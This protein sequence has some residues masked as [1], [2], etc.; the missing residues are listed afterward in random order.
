MHII[1]KTRKIFLI[2]SV[3]VT[4]GWF[5]SCTPS[6]KSF[7]PEHPLTLWYTQPAESWMEYSLPIGNGHMGA[8]LF[9]GIEKDEIQFNEKTLW[10]GKPYAIGSRGKYMNFGSVFAEFEKSDTS[11]TVSH[12]TRYLDLETGVGGVQYTNSDGSTIYDR[13][14]LASAPDSAVVALYKA[15]GK[16]KLNVRFSLVPAK[17]L[18]NVTVKYGGAFEYNSPVIGYAV[19][20]YVSDINVGGATTIKAKYGATEAKKAM[21]SNDSSKL[22]WSDP[23]GA[24]CTFAK[25]LV[26]LQNEGLLN[27]DVLTATSDNC[28]DAFV[29]GKC[30]MFSNGMWCLSSILEKDPSMADKI[31]FAP[32]PSF[33][34]DGV[35]VVLVAEDSGYSISADT[36]NVEEAKDF[37]TYL[38][39]AEN[40]KKYAESLGSPSAF[41]DVDAKWAP[42]AV[43]DGV[44]AAI[45]SATNIGFTNEKPAGFSGDDAGR[46]VQELLAG[47]YTP[48]EYAKAYEDAWNAGY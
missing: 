31:G 24:M 8:C 40:Q 20:A 42:Q 19:N 29:T 1:M 14:Y 38:F 30:A 17:G 5:F 21:L 32:Y 9:G 7:A 12:Y 43:V 37:L 39:S 13:K 16:E 18:G 33:M 41:Q 6:V 26:E 4:L 3:I 23:D 27:E 10:T 28:V 25:N 34:S 35:P 46:L 22:N 2:V 11:D 15:R 44:N 36:E 45:A 47:V 48:E